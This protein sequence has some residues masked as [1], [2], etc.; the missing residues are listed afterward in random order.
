MTKRKPAP[1]KRARAKRGRVVT[2]LDIV[3]PRAD[4]AGLRLISRALRE[5]WKIPRTVAA[6][7]PRVVLDMIDTAAS[8]RDRLRAIECL[9][10]MQRYNHDALVS[11]DKCERLDGGAATE[12]IELAPIT[13][14][15]G[16]AGY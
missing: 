10:S 11:A 15:P 2:A 7:L 8:D 13:L 5:G 9:M 4:R 14:R 12:R 1:T 3:E 6:T 16:G